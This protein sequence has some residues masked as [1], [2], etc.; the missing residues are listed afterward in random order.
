MLM[1][2]LT[3]GLGL[4]VQTQAM[5]RTAAPA[6]F[7]PGPCPFWS[8]EESAKYRV[9]C[10][11]LR[12]EESETS[13]RRYRLQVAILRSREDRLHND[14][15]VVLTGGEGGG[16]LRQGAASLAQHP[17]QD[18]LRRHRDIV[19]LDARGTGYSEPGELCPAL[20]S[21][22]TRTAIL[23]LP[24]EER[25]A[26]VR[27]MLAAC[28][29][30]LERE[31]VDPGHFNSVALARDL[32]TLRVT[33]GYDRLNLIGISWGT[34]VALEM[35][36][37]FPGSVRSVVM[38]GPFPPD[39]AVPGGLAG[40]A[41]PSLERL[42]SACAAD[43]TC[44]AEY[45]EVAREFRAL[46]AELDADP[47]E[48][49]TPTGVFRVDG[50]A[51]E[52]MVIYAL[53]D[54]EF[55]RYVP[56]AIRELRRRNASFLEILLPQAIGQGRSGGFYYAAHCFE[57]PPPIAA[58]SLRRLRERFPWSGRAERFGPDPA[59]VC[60]AFV[61]R[62]ADRT[63]VQPV[64]SDV[65]TLIFVGEFDPTT[66]QEY[67]RRIASTVVRSHVVVLKGRGHDVNAPTECT[68]RIRRAFLEDP[69]SPP[70]TSCAASA[71]PVAFRTDLHVNAGV[72]RLLS[73][74]VVPGEPVWLAG[75]ALVLLALL[76]GA[77][78]LP[79]RGAARLRHARARLFSGALWAASATALLFTAG[80]AVA[81][82]ASDRYVALFGVP[83][84]WAWLFVLPAL[85]AAFSAVGL[86]GLV[87][88][89]S[90]DWW[91]RRARGV[92]V[93]GTLASIAFLWIGLH[94]G[95]W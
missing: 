11:M 80:L 44:R 43:S 18:T 59:T 21:M 62:A 23:R 54:S 32:E 87:M 69:E 56:L 14:A 84:L 83:G 47:V 34:R 17:L 82:V 76:P 46:L 16:L 2:L 49:S 88:G 60:G 30:R 91:T 57:L 52:T 24:F 41:G 55:L 95:L 74:L 28:R 25:T 10:G 70:D 51:A 67:G 73:R 86:I 65:P 93:L 89:W 26:L 19:L 1:G 9:E 92:R 37:R 61:P 50:A 40:R 63:V 27:R 58:D 39:G 20:E 4:S 66:P 8:A 15:I 5:S 29:D 45:P 72:P 48:L 68:A 90:T 12:V 13:A 35:L 3:I 94:L 64:R 85:V 36:R 33:L 42:F 78:L 7:E 38:Y 79:E 81:L 31:G 6:A 77:A 71:A 22:E 75:I 53:Y